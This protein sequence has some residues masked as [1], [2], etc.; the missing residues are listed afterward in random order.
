MNIEI[1]ASVPQ[2]MEKTYIHNY[3]HITHNTNRIFLFTGDQKFEHF[4]KDFYGPN[5]PKEVND[6]EHLFKV[7][8]VGHV[9]GFVTQLGLIE[10]YGKKYPNINYIVKLNTKTNLLSTDVKDPSSNIMWSVQD[11]LDFKKISGLNICGI[12]RT[13]Y[14]GST[15]EHETIKSIEQAIY[16][17][18]KNGL[19]GILFV[20]PKGQYIE[21]E[22]EPDMIAGAAA[23]G[24]SLGADIVKVK[25]TK[26]VEDLK[27][28]VGAAGNTKVIC[29]GGSKKDD[30]EFLQT[31]YEQIHHAGTSGVAVGR[32]IYQR[33]L[34]AAIAF[35][36][37]I[38]AIVY[39]DKTTDQAM[40]IYEKNK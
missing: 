2:Q 17:A 32:N 19:V 38:A 29:A 28:A 15:Y 23:V 20:Y 12:A 14:P 3:K 25:P 24:V 22:T 37:A 10:R 9:G 39:K 34:T 40:K 27:Q 26:K 31:I 30:Q 6:P 33:T 18:H 4:N 36:Q 1:P 13:I 5:I 11:V 7:A 35:T 8:S 16:P 21:Y